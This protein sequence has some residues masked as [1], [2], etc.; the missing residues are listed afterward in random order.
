NLADIRLTKEALKESKILNTLNVVNNGE[1]AMD[2]LFKK[3]KYK[4]MRRPDIILL[5]LNLPKKDGREV[6]AEI[7]S[8]A[9]LKTIPVVILTVSQAEEDIIKTYNHYA[10]CYIV[11]PMDMEQFIKIVNSIQNFWFRIVKLPL[12]HK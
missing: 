11:K 12:K 3:G 2:Y 4:N 1:E 6:L 5:D 10:N 7:K 9:E 8:N